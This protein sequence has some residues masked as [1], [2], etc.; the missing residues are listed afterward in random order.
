[1]YKIKVDTNLLD[2]IAKEYSGISEN[3]YCAYESV[4]TA[5]DIV[6]EFKGFNIDILTE[7]LYSEARNLKSIGETASD[8]RRKTEC[9]SEIY[10]NAENTVERDVNNLPILV[11]NNISVVGNPAEVFTETITDNDVSK[12]VSESALICDNTVMHEDWLI[13]LI[14]KNK[15]GG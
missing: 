11:H 8:I 12:N 10:S 14:A 4:K 15:Y 1:M 13:K 5:A 7:Q 2:G 6:A 9:I 3:L